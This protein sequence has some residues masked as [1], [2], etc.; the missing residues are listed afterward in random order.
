MNKHSVRGATRLPDYG[1]S[2]SEPFRII[3]INQPKPYGKI[4]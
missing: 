3:I 2:R 1:L 4:L